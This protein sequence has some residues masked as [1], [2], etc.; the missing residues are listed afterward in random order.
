MKST[1]PAIVVFRL[2]VGKRVMV[3]M[4]DSPAVSLLQL[5]VLP[6]PSEVTTPMPV[7]TTI[8]RPNLSRAA[9][10]TL[11]SFQIGQIGEWQALSRSMAIRQRN[12][13]AKF[14]AEHCRDRSS[15]N[16]RDDP[17]PDTD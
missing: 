11:H 14:A 1:V 17:K 16:R 4:P 9:I 10:D 5:S 13:A 3:R 7:I 15:K 6:A 8:G 12:I 2:S